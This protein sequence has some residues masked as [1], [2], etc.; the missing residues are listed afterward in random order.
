MEQ[1]SRVNN[2]K[3]W[4]A[5]IFCRHHGEWFIRQEP[6]FNLSGETKN[7]ELKIAEVYKGD[8]WD[9]TCVSAI[10]PTMPGVT[11]SAPPYQKYT[12]FGDKEAV[13]KAIGRYT[14]E[15]KPYK[16]EPDPDK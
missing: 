9:D 2:P 1:E 4:I 10:V 8:R 16:Y 12:C 5:Q 7:I 14:S 13:L 15:Y 6:Y 11:A 3:P